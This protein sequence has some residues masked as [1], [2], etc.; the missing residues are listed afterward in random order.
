MSDS[1]TEH[2]HTTET[3]E[4]IIAVEFIGNTPFFALAD[5]SVFYN[6]TKHQLHEGGILVA[7]SNGK[8]LYTGGDDGKIIATAQDGSN[9]IIAH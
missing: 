7:H 3:D 9:T 1:L 4:F 8:T 2:V 6:D 5:G